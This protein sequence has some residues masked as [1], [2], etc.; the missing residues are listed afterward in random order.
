[1]DDRGRKLGDRLTVDLLLE[2]LDELERAFAAVQRAYVEL[3]ATARA[4]GRAPHGD[5]GVRHAGAPG[6]RDERAWVPRVATHLH[7]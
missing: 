4:R 1:M 5:D 2:R 3:Q 6:E 7:A